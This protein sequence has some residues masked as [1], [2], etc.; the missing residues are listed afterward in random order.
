[1]P[2]SLQKKSDRKIYRENN[3]RSGEKTKSDDRLLTA[4]F[5][6]T[7]FISASKILST[8]G[9]IAST[10]GALCGG[11]MGCARVTIDA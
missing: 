9:T 11:G 5:S 7:N 6:P 2:S 8:L 4:Y 3:R 1:M 10:S